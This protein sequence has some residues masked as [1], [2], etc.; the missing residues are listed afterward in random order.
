MKYVKSI[1]SISPYTPGLNEDDIKRKYNIDKVIK[2][3][4]NENPYGTTK[5]LNSIYDKVCIERYPDNYCTKLRNV[6]SK[7]Y[8]I[9]ENKFIFGNGSVEIIQMITRMLIEKNDEV[10]T[11]NPTFQSYYLETYIQ[12]GKVINV[13]VKK[14]ME[15][16]LDGILEKINTKTKVIYI[17]N[18]NNPTGLI[19]TDKELT[20]FLDSVP[21]DILIVLDEA[22]AE[23]VIDEDYPNSIR[24]LDKYK[25]I[26][27]LRTFSKA[28]GLANLRI[29]YAVAH[30]EII[31]NLEKVRLPFN[32]SSIAE[33][34]ALLALQDKKFLKDSVSKNR[35]VI[36]YLYKSMDEKNI[37]YVKTQTNFILIYIKSDIDLVCEKLLYEGFIVRP[38]KLDIGNYIRVTI[39]TMD[40]MKKFIES[41]DRIMR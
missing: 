34:A 15:F 25:N 16:D 12:N 9:P 30:E 11:C 23:Y 14:N 38:V 27:I 31:T 39:G 10:I 22:Y 36:E 26:C 17:A 40:Q 7:K 13:P 41:L 2:L 32:V 37:H 20:K 29:G 18:P 4:S 21:E 19:I 35:K 33:E 24:L 28:Y 5:T 3:A 6:L 1:K 8:S